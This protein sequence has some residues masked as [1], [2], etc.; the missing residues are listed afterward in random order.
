MQKLY[1]I[2]F[3]CCN[4]KSLTEICSFNIW[5]FFTIIL[6]EV[7]IAANLCLNNPWWLALQ[8]NTNRVVLVHFTN[9]WP[10]LFHIRRNFVKCSIARHFLS[11]IRRLENLVLINKIGF[12]LFTIIFAKDLIRRLPS[13]RHRCS[14]NQRDPCLQRDLHHCSVFGS[15]SYNAKTY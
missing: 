5:P 15:S 2:P 12:G 4:N 11:W 6:A 3:G 8:L 7:D 9:V 1:F 14:Q 13:L 10:N